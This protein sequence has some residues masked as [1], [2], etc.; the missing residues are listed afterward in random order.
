[1]DHRPNEIGLRAE[2]EVATACARAGMAVYVPLLDGHGRVDLVVERNGLLLRVQCKSARM[3]GDD[4]VYFR[5]CSN[6]ANI[7]R[8]YDGE[9][10]VFGVYAPVIH[11][12]FLVPAEALPSRICHLRLGPTR[13]GQQKGIRFAADFEVRPLCSLPEEEPIPG[14]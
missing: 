11:K 3:D 6:T 9:I 7:P 5:T 4:V 1:M 2:L 14:D 8:T 12:V 13:N 10:D